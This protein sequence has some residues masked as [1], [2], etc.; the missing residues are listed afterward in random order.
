MYYL[1]YFNTVLLSRIHST[2]WRKAN[3][4]FHKPC[5]VQGHF[6]PLCRLFQGV[7][8]ATTLRCSLLE[9]GAQRLV[10]LAT[11]HAYS[12]GASWSVYFH[13][14][15]CVWIA[16]FLGVHENGRNFAYDIPR[17]M[18]PS[19]IRHMFTVCLLLFWTFLSSSSFHS[20][21][22]KCSAFC[23]KCFLR[24]KST[25]STCCPAWLR[26]SFSSKNHDAFW[27]V[28]YNFLDYRTL[29]HWSRSCI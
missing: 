16:I 10:V 1:R 19:D 24:T 4:G 2:I 13:S 11:L 23:V 27:S 22:M 20:Q 12:Q 26:L 7:L 18:N 15:R 21:L 6:A 8:Q 14:E 29:F 25:G 9:S 17:G 5:W 3:H 28:R